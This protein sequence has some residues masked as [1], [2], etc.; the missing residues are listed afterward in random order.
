MPGS[1]VAGRLLLLLVLAPGPAGAATFVWV[2][3]SGG[4]HATS[5]PASV[6]A[7]ARARLVP[8]GEA[9]AR[10]W[11][12]GI[13]GPRPAAAHDGTH[14]VR[15]RA[16]R[17]VNGAV[18][19]LARGET[20]RA[21]SA[22]RQAL[23]LA[24]G[25]AEAHWYLALLEQQ[26]GHFDTAEDHLRDF[27]ASA[28]ESLS[29]FRPSA[30]R[31]LAALSDEARLERPGAAPS[32]L[33]RLAEDHPR[34]RLEVDAALLA[35]EA[36]YATTALRYLEEARAHAK[37]Q[38]GVEP[39][40]PTGVV[41]YG[42]A[43]YTEAH[44]HRFSFQT[45]G[46]YDGRIHVVSAAHPAGELRALLFHE[47]THAVFRERTGDDSPYW[48][49][50]GLAE[51]SGRSARRQDL[52]S[53]SEREQLR[54]AIEDGRWTPLP[55]LSAGFAG[56]SDVSARA[57]YLQSTAAA[58]WIV[59]RTDPA[60]RAELL[61]RL[62]EGESEDDA[63]RAVVGRDTMGIDAAVRESVLREFPAFGP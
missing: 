43:A 51:L 13:S 12:D 58:E 21:A 56:L 14:D 48:L 61:R 49:N 7:D 59:R 42:R 34:F 40:E 37:T 22:L 2:D 35:N 23:A 26:R 8:E 52:L 45:V 53:R 20:A 9:R 4:T 41:L 55:K 16:L 39:S 47:F 32:P 27:L 54:A 15:D 19:D 50:E 24:P 3:G 63:L 36:D 44:R 17:L 33:L 38:L 28:G 5:D 46:F 18:D 57:A 10:L 62:G 30:E 29:A 25:T 1:S 11:E 31:R 60:S 6:P